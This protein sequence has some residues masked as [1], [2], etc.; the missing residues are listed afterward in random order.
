[1]RTV[2]PS[3]H[4]LQVSRGP[5]ND[6]P[7]LP[8]HKV[9][10]HDLILS[11]RPRHIH[12]TTYPP[13]K[14]SILSWYRWHFALVWRPGFSAPTTFWRDTPPKRPCPTCKGA[15]NQSVHGYIVYWL[16][17]PLDLAWRAAWGPHSPAL[18]W[19]IYAQR[20]EVFVTGK[21]AILDSLYAYLSRELGKKGALKAITSF[22]DK[23]LDL[24]PADL[25]PIPEDYKTPSP[26][27]YNIAN[28]DITRAPP[29]SRRSNLPVT[30]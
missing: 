5:I 16:T 3:C 26:S 13:I 12:P 25:P 27:P 11:H 10:T 29:P 24:L 19:R 4:S 8:P 20:R 23:V 2:V 15:Y 21:L 1:M 14:R 18:S 28:W 7:F 9:W 6:E 17:H 30:V 22:W